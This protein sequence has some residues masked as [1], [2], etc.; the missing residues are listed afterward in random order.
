MN[1]PVYLETG[2]GHTLAVYCR[3]Q[4]N[5]PAV[6]VCHGGPG[7]SINDAS[8]ECFDLDQWF[9]IA[10]DQRGCGRSTPF[11]SLHNNTIFH[12]VSDMEIIRNHFNLDSWVVFG[13]SYGTTLALTYAI[14]H[15]HR[16]KA[17]VL[18]GI[19]LGRDEDIQWLYQ[20]GC[21]YFF[22]THFESFKAVIP[23]EK[24]GDLVSAYYEIFKSA[25]ESLKRRAAK[26]WADWEMSV[27]RL[28]PP[29]DLSS[30]EIKDSDISLALLECH[31][32][33]NHMFWDDDNYILNNVSTIQDIATYIAHGRY[34]VDCR[35]SGAYELALHLDKCELVFTEASGH[36]GSEPNTQA[37]LTRFMKHLETQ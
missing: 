33:A 10:F 24:Q 29:D 9:V 32:F 34:D 23:K 11:A 1:E 8:F 4:R 36:S 19:F 22:P 5:K 25:D 37:A 26:A 16:V 30:I 3:G 14:H 2:D 6:I 15:K 12:S 17:L 13:G 20:A 35:P 18:R 27:V 28:I 7:G 21:S 31:Y